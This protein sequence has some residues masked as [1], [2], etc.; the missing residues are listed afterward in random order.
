QFAA[1]SLSDLVGVDVDRQIARFASGQRDG[2]ALRDLLAVHVQLNA[3]RVVVPALTL[4]QLRGHELASGASRIR[5]VTREENLGVSR[6][7]E[8]QLG[9]E[10]LLI[11]GP[12][13]DLLA[14]AIEAEI[15]LSR[16]T[17]LQLHGLGL[18]D[19]FAVAFGLSTQLI[20]VVE[21]R[22]QA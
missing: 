1:T 10:R 21:A 20:G 16:L 6:N 2:L 4:V 22:T 11:S 9:L 17:S 7:M 3:N 13:F 18:F 15:D 12:L 8:G 14:V 5:L 19:H